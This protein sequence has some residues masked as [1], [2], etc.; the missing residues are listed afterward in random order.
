MHSEFAR[1]QELFNFISALI[2]WDGF[3]SRIDRDEFQDIIDF[4]EERMEESLEFLGDHVPTVVHTMKY[5]T[6]GGPI[7]GGGEKDLTDIA[8]L[9]PNERRGKEEEAVAT[10]EELMRIVEPEKSLFDNESEAMTLLRDY[11]V[12]ISCR[13]PISCVPTVHELSI[14]HDT[15]IAEILHVQFFRCREN[16]RPEEITPKMQDF[17][18]NIHKSLLLGVMYRMKSGH[19]DNVDSYLEH[20]DSLEKINKNPRQLISLIKEKSRPHS[21]HLA[22]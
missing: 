17:I 21:Y 4:I 22:D 13:L 2:I 3:L 11:L 9:M 1:F 8:E 7:N 12:E 16:V 15:A 18:R 6:A 19:A 14:S 10:I 5:Y 20:L